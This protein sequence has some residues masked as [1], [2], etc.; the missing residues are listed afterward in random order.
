MKAIH[1]KTLEPLRVPLGGGK[2]LHLGPGQRGHV[3]DDALEIAGVR[4]LI[5]SGAIAVEGEEGRPGEFGGETGP[6]REDPHGHVHGNKVF[7]S[8]NRGG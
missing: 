6:P 1:N 7:P 3:Q 2:L 8:G 5:E 4:R